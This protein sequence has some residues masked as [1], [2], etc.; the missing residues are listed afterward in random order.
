MLTADTNL[1]IHAADPDSIQHAR[2]REFFLDVSESGEE[3]VLWNR[4]EIT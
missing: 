1:L 2:A 4:P 3:F